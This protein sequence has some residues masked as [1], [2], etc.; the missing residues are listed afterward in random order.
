MRQITYYK[1]NMLNLRGK[2]GQM[3]ID[4]IKNQPAVSDAELKA[5]A[6]ACIERIKKLKELEKSENRK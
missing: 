4:F 6:D 3:I 1:P 5:S 2:K